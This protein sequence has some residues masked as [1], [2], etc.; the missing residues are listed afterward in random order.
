M[1]GRE[2]M[3]CSGSSPGDSS[4][5]AT[6]LTSAASPHLAWHS[7][8]VRKRFS[9]PPHPPYTSPWQPSSCDQAN[10]G[11]NPLQARRPLMGG[12]RQEGWRAVA[13]TTTTTMVLHHN[14]F[15][16]HQLLVHRPGVTPAPGVPP[17]WW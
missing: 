12:R 17:D 11:K 5:S 16:L 14:M 8:M 7:S 13:P 9:D 6:T 2:Q 4:T 15:S 10:L 3:S 1:G